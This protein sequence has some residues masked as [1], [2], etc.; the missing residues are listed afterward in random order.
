MVGQLLAELTKKTTARRRPDVSQPSGLE[1]SP[2]AGAVS[3]P[4]PPH[5][6]APSPA[7]RKWQP[8]PP[9][10]QNGRGGGEGIF[11]N[12]HFAFAIVRSVCATQRFM[13]RGGKTTT[14]PEENLLASLQVLPVS[15]GS[16]HILRQTHSVHPPCSA[17]NSKT[18]ATV[19]IC[20][21][22][23]PGALAEL[24]GFALEFLVSHPH[25]A[26]L[27]KKDG[28]SSLRGCVL[29]CYKE[30]RMRLDATDKPTCFRGNPP[31]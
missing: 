14:S 7:P 5:W 17:C 9:Q 16:P 10:G 26:L 20:V 24:P 23:C 25:I 6:A 4:P 13:G 1:P 19:K 29:G 30:P 18:G 3:P 31:Q 21:R 12:R 11:Q 8:P 27:L 22:S 2:P 28:R 15:A